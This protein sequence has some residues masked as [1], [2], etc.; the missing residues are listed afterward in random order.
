LRI[1][2]VHPDHH[3]LAPNDRGALRVA[4]WLVGHKLLLKSERDPD[5][6]CQSGTGGQVAIASVVQGQF[7]GQIRLNALKPLVS[8]VLWRARR[9][10]NT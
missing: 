8:L 10:A 3:Q 9:Y 7:R 6:C 1:V 5:S 2:L 4:E